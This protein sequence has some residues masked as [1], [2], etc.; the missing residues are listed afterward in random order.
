MTTELYNQNKSNNE[1]EIAIYAHIG[2]MN[3]LSHA[4]STIHQEQLE[5]EFFNGVRCRVRKEVIG[6]GTTYTLTYKVKQ[7]NTGVVSSNKE[8]NASVD[9]DFFE[10]FRHVAKKRIK[11]TR[12]I[13]NSRLVQFELVPTIGETVVLTLPQ[14]IYEVDVYQKVDNTSSEWCKIDIELD[15]ILAAIPKDLNMTSKEIKAV[16]KISHLPFKPIHGML[17]SSENSKTKTIIS[18]IW[19]EEWNL[20]VFEK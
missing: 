2:D 14:V 4:V 16:I 3:G 6:T 11:K 15:G 10:G 7:E 20:P 19:D 18:K 1:T 8:Y 5:T 13:F 12:Y 9:S 17:N